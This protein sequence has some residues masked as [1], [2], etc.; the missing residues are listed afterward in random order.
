MPATVSLETLN[1]ASADEFVAAVGFIFEGSPWIARAAYEDRPF[2]D[3][4]ALYDALCAVLAEASADDRLALIRAHPELAGSTARGGLTAASRDE[5]A[6]A[7]LSR[8]S[9]EDQH[10]FTRMN[11]AYRKRFGFPFVICVREH[12]VDSILR[13]LERR[14]QNPRTVEIE[15]AL[16]EIA[17]IA[18]HR[19]SGVI[20]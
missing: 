16:T 18:R 11:A 20:A 7:G 12:T 6:A 19:L 17:K 10:A 1:D 5:Q 9:A 4:S 14:L 8:L 15:T 3:F 2:P 13:S